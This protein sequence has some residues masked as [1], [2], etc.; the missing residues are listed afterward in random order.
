MKVGLIVVF[1]FAGF[2]S[3]NGEWA[4]FDTQAGGFSNIP[5]TAFAIQLMYISF[6]YSGWNAAAYIAGEV[7]RPEN[8]L[9][10]SLL[11]GTGIVTVLYLLLNVIYFYALP[12]SVLG[13]PADKFE[14]V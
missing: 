4:H 10:R 13:G 7:E 12:S 5:T 6:A 1:I 9:P 3:G 14:P 8:T 11:L 2:A